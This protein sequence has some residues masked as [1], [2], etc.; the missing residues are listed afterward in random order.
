[1][2]DYQALWNDTLDK[3]SNSLSENTFQETFGEVKH[4]M[5]E[6]NGVIYI[7]TPSTYIKSKINNIYVR[8]VNEIL[9]SLTSKKLKFKFVIE[10]ELKNKP[11]QPAFT[12][13][14]KHN[15]NANYTFESFVIGD[16]N[17]LGY[18]TATRVADEPGTIFNPLYIFGGVG[19]GK[20]HLMQAIGN[21]ISESD[22]N[23][24]ILYVQANEYLEDY[25]KAS[26]DKNMKAFE[27][28]YENLD[29]L[30]VDDIQMLEKGKASQEEFFKLFNNMISRQKQIV[31][32]SD[33]P[34]TK[35]NG[36]MDRLTSRFS[37]GI[38]VDIK[39]PDL[40][41]RLNILKRKLAETSEITIDDDVLNYIA[42][43]FTDNVRELEGALTR[44]LWVSEVYNSKPTLQMTKEA[45][46]ILIKAKKPT[47]NQNYEN[48]LSVIANIYNIS[49]VD[50]LGNSRNAKYVLP[51]HIAMYILKN[52]YKLTYSRIGSILNGRDHT[53]IMNGCN[54]IEQDLKTNEQ[55]KMAIDSILKKV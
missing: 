13:I 43:N 47:L 46:E 25:V 26:R 48:A 40:N 21:Y 30:L 9:S 53:T 22:L 17:R 3:L 28:K 33:C 36:I 37:M 51:R 55:L 18:L 19:L 12:K 52:H 35:L 4:V 8:Q 38:T 1:M 24:K 34:A 49:V 27:E 7:L 20:T 41:Q 31:I 16:S 50:L 32:T 2:N 45:L 54:K 11:S 5:K 23:N 10:E 44:V 29:V 42:E 15:L 6:E 39:L 14:T